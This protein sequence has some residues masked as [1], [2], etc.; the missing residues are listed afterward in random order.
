MI[1]AALGTGVAPPAPPLSVRAGS[2][3][4]TPEVDPRQVSAASTS[5]APDASAPSIDA[6]GYTSLA[7]LAPP[8]AFALASAGDAAPAQWATGPEY[9][10][11]GLGS[12]HTGILVTLG[13]GTL[14]VLWCNDV[15]PTGAPAACALYPAP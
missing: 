10:G 5:S 13:T 8:T 11:V 2:V 12:S 14:G 7:A 1:H 6:L 15:N 9:L 4:V 3:L